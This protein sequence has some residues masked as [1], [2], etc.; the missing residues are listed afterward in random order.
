M[1]NDLLI[2][3]IKLLIAVALG[4][5]IGLEREAHGR[6]AGL[7]TH[8]LVCLGSAL[9]T[10]ISETYTGKNSD[11]SR[12]AAQIVTGVGFLGAGTIIRQGSMIRGLTTAASLWTVAAIGMAVGTSEWTNTY[13][14]VVASVIVYLT[15]GLINRIERGMISRQNARELIVMFAD[16]SSLPRALDVI[17]RFGITVQSVVSE[18]EDGA[19]TSRL[20]LLLPIGTDIT[21]ISSQ[22]SM[23][24]SIISFS[25]E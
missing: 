20:S 3:I 9:F 19:S 11:P 8:I 14:A 16:R 21:A 5:V 17:S 13:L 18:D 24:P 12:V 4:G 2:M 15:L 22:L 7:R 23:I 6:P 25:W 10:L 1:N